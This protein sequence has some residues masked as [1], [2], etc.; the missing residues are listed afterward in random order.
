[1]AGTGSGRETSKPAEGS[2]P[3]NVVAEPLS[4]PTPTPPPPLTPDSSKRFASVIKYFRPNQSKI[5]STTISTTW[6]SRR[7]VSK[8]SAKTPTEATLR[9]KIPEEFRLATPTTPKPQ[10]LDLFRRPSLP[11]P[12]AVFEPGL[13]Q[14]IQLE[15]RFLEYQEPRE[16]ANQKSSLPFRE[17]GVVDPVPKIPP[18][19]ETP[20]VKTI[21][22]SPLVRSSNKKPD[23]SSESTASVDKTMAS[24]IASGGQYESFQEQNAGLSTATGNQPAPSPLPNGQNLSS[25]PTNLSGLVCNV[26]RTTGRE[27]HPLVGPSSTVLGDKLYV[28]GGRLQSRSRP[29]LL[30]NEMYELDL[31]RRHW[32][33]L[34]T[35]GDIPPPRYFHTVCALGDSK[36]VCYGGMSA[37]AA[38]PN[39]PPVNPNP[40]AQQSGQEAQQGV[41]LLSDVHIFDVL[42]RTWVFIP[43]VNAPRGRYAHCAT[44][45]PSGAAFGSSNAP[46]SALHH[47][48]SSSNPHQG[49]IG[50]EIDGYGG[51][52]MIVVG[53]QDT[54]NHYFEEINVFNLR[55]LKWTST[56]SLDRSCGAYRSVATPLLGVNPADIGGGVEVEGFRDPTKPDAQKPDPLLLIYSNYNFL[57]V[58]LN[59][60]LRLPDGKLIEKPMHGTVSPPGLRFPNGG[61]IN[62]HFVVSG[63]YL[64]SSKQE[65]AMWALDLKTLTWGRIDAGGAIFGHGSWNRGVLWSRRSTFV[66]MGHRKRSLVEDYNHRRINF[67]HICFV[68]L[69]AFGLYEN[70]RRSAPTSGYASVSCPMVP[71]SLQA[72]ISQQG[73]GGRPLSAAA[74]ELGR[75]ALSLRELS[76]ME[77]L[78]I[79]GERI[80]V[81]SHILARRWGP[82]FIQLLRE[83]TAAEEN[84]SDS[85]TLRQQTPSHPSRNSSITI[86]PSVGNHSN[87]SAA[88]TLVSHTSSLSNQKAA[89][90]LLPNLEIP[91]A[92]TLTPTSRPRTLYLPHTHLTVQ[93]LVQYLYTSSL[94]PPGSQLCTPQILCSLLQL[95]RPYQVDGLLEATVER[96]HQVLDGRNAA[97]VF[98]AAAMAAGGGRGTGFTSGPGGTLEVLNGVHSRSNAV[99]SATEPMSTLN[100]NSNSSDTESGNTSGA[101]SGTISGGGGPGTS[102][103]RTSSAQRP[104]NLRIN[105]TNLNA[106]NANAGGSRNRAESVSSAASTATSASTNTS[107]SFSESMGADDNNNDDNDDGVGHERGRSKPEREIWTG[108]ISSVV[109]LQK[110]GLRGL[111]E[112]RRMRERGG[113]SANTPGT[114]G[115]GGED[116]NSAATSGVPQTPSAATAGIAVGGGG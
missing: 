84:I 32:T 86:T 58:K 51:A 35:T 23:S 79:G 19:V 68:E 30:T 110:R 62:G 37:K 73:A 98:N 22:E 83:S 34:E 105:T 59:L 20:T 94:P 4:T 88:T 90:S 92:H 21:F 52:E 16:R 2:S 12:A 82:Y 70:P 100:L 77:L 31:I 49:S 1:M 114:A 99:A 108:E 69:E 10:D 7:F 3:A 25:G 115:G 46:L 95:A 6:P 14:N 85:A 40:T 9:N 43:T 63:T 96:L 80:P 24:N 61:I 28:F 93:L 26:H 97:A 45:L 112:G 76:D 81:N 111:M 66:V 54:S 41:V 67:S 75:M 39:Q 42:T 60:Q 71:A 5:R 11:V 53:G 18:L 78:T 72:K 27:P 101:L 103:R 87:Y 65:Y 17:S 33:K 55:S 113:R 89:P 107:V 57:D 109:G 64:T 91:S 15:R 47:N 13:G 106:G 48:P 38:V 74:E 50:V 29:E 8:G 102:Q 36:L 116:G 56:T 44:I 104:A